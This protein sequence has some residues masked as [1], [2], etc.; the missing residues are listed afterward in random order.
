MKSNEEVMSSPT[1][2]TTYDSVNKIWRGPVRPSIFNTEAGLGNVILNVLRQ[3]P[4]R[5][6]QV[7][8]DTGSEMTC[9]EMYSRTVK[10]I[11][12][13]RL[14]TAL[15]QHDVVG[16]IARNSENIA[17]VAFACFSLGLP[18]NPLAPVLGEKEIGEMYSKTKP[19]AIFCD[20]DL[21]ETV[22]NV[23]KKIQVEN[24]KIITLMEKV[25]G[26]DF[27]DEICD[28]ELNEFE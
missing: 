23:I 22:L 16:I 8:Y 18:I 21:I 17:A 20:N 13:L 19:K 2:T 6:M 15:T 14:K 7:C 3:N 4:D 1:V 10:I 27:V 25:E 28:G 26:F 24:C 9:G 5:V 11:N 12:F